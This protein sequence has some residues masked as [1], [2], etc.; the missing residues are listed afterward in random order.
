M[1]LSTILSIAWEGLKQNKIR[2]FLTTLGIIIGVAAVI[3]MLAISAGAE[4]AIADQI[5]SLGANLLII[6]PMRGM[7][8]ASKTLVLDDALAINERIIN[9]DGV[10]AEQAP[11]SQTI[12]ANNITLE[13]IQVIGTT[14]DFP[15]VRDF[16]VDLGRYF[17][18][19][20]DE[21]KARVVVLG[22]AI[23][24]D[25]FGEQD[26]IGQTITVGTSKLTVIGVM[27]PKG[28]VADIDY[29]GRIYIPIELAFDKFITASSM[30]GDR[31]K[32]I[33]VKV[34]DSENM[35]SIIQ[36]ITYL[37]A[38]RHN[39]EPYDADFSISTQQDII[40]TQEATTEAFRSLLGW[41][42]GV[43]LLVGGIGIMNIMLVSVTERTREIGLRQALGARPEDVLK[44]FLIEAII[45]SLAGGLIGVLLGIVG[46]YLFGQLGGMRTEIVPISIPISFGAAAIIG[47]FF[48]FYPAQ[49]A[50]K[51]EPIVALRHE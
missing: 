31:V 32:T 27:S 23:A 5:N 41:V 17:T 29:D 40:A 30:S 38:E 3:I 37:M 4:A 8:G 49:Q 21:R 45:L 42:A 16:P 44:Q 50:A 18:S 25:L 24:A 13:E 47:I 46:A 15:I 36:Q 22:T 12:K 48:G 6:G 14:S 19:E 28:V 11:P 34:S 7:P 10:S 9:I 51:L 20:E 43:S 26:P 33:Y 2:S 39:V 35:E 1:K